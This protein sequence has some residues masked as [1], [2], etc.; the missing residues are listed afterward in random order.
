[1]INRDAYFCGT[2]IPF[3]EPEMVENDDLV[4]YPA[5]A[6]GIVPIFNIPGVQNIT[7]PR[8][9][10]AQIFD[11]TIENWN[12]V[13]IVASNPL[14]SSV[15]DPILVVARSDASGETCIL[16]QSLSAFDVD[17]ASNVGAGEAVN[18]T[19]NIDFDRLVLVSSPS[20][21]TSVVRSTPVSCIVLIDFCL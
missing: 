12:D 4:V 18:W 13:D 6:V 10:L 5:V 15:S 14:L 11:G 16:T 19:A 7:L 3:T 21:M 8:N 1:M 20:Q 17:F 2:D 9:V